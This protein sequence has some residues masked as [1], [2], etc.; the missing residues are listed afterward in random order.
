MLSDRCVFCQIIAGE[1]PAR[2]IFRDELV[3]AFH[4]SA[5]V[6]P[7]HVLVVPNRHIE[8]LQTA[9]EADAGLLGH[10]LL[11]AKQVAAQEGLAHSGFRVSINTGPDAGQSVYHLHLHVLGGRVMRWPPG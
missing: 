2:V 1:A 9:G 10:M 6:T 5:P 8:S 3:T 7:V 11:V 4:D